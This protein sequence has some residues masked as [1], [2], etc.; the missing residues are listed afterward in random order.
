MYCCVCAFVCACVWT[1]MSMLV[2]NDNGL[3]ACVGGRLQLLFSLQTRHLEAH[4]ILITFLTAG[5][6]FLKLPSPHHFVVSFSNKRLQV[7]I[8]GEI[9]A[10]HMNLKKSLSGVLL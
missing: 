5:P 7:F 9:L 10:S 6:A 3:F 8:D 4:N 2:F 1:R